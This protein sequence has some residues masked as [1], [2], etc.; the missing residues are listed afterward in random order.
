MAQVLTDADIDKASPHVLTD[1]DIDAHASGSHQSVA[2]F[3]SAHPNIAAKDIQQ[4]NTTPQDHPEFDRFMQEHPYLGGI[5]HSLWKSDPI[6]PVPLEA[7]VA[8]TQAILK[9]GGQTAGDFLSQVLQHPKTVAAM[10]EAA[11]D[12]LREVP[13]VKGM[14]GTA[15][16][17]GKVKGVVDDVRAAQALSEV[18]TV[19]PG[20]PANGLPLRPPLAQPGVPAP[21]GPVVPVRP[22]LAAPVPAPPDIPLAPPASGPVTPVRP[23]LQA[24]PPAAYMD[25]ES[26]G[27]GVPQL[28]ANRARTAGN[29]AR[30]LGEQGITDADL[31]ALENH[32]AAY[33]AFWENAGQ[34]HREGYVPSKD[35]VTAVKDLLK[36]GK[37]TLVKTP[38]QLVPEPEIPAYLA[39]NPKALAAAR[40]LRSSSIGDLMQQTGK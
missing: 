13:G 31:D 3:R 26:S 37:P 30:K 11:M 6:Q 28:I 22:P 7:P 21:S 20:A 12:W 29:I 38:A 32:P 33:K 4:L 10:K 25:T 39:R 1:A 5:L 16:A 24:A 18:P 9:A 2:D 35:T 8:A 17:V 36:T 40:A 15:K 34:L 19:Q 23:P 14:M 27:L